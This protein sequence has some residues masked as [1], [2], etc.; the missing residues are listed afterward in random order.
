[1]QN[2]QSSHAEFLEKLSKLLDE[3]YKKSLSERVK[4]G[5]AQRRQN[6]QSK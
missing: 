5:I 6:G 2:N 4:K 1:M 3:Q